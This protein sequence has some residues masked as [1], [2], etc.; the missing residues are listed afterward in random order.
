MKDIL[1]LLDPEVHRNYHK[2]KAAVLEAWNDITDAE[3]KDMIHTMPAR[4]KAVIEANGL[5]ESM[6][7]EMRRS[8]AGSGANAASYLNG[9]EMHRNLRIWIEEKKDLDLNDGSRINTIAVVSEKFFLILWVRSFSPSTTHAF[10][11]PPPHKHASI[12]KN[13]D[14][15]RHQNLL[16]HYQSPSQAIGYSS[17]YSVSGGHYPALPMQCIPSPHLDIC[18]PSHPV[19]RSSLFY[20]YHFPL[21]PKAGISPTLFQEKETHDQSCS[22]ERHHYFPISV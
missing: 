1:A 4:C 12:S 19:F 22:G 17:L 16:F 15:Q 2:L 5:G 7:V 20:L 3:V 18:T 21:F 8:D 10:T 6:G 13:S 14:S 9:P 11:P